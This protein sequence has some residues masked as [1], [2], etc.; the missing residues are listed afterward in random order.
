MTVPNRPPAAGLAPAGGL[1]PAHIPRPHVGAPPGPAPVAPPAGT[2][3]FAPP[4][5][6]RVLVETFTERFPWRGVRWSMTYVGFLGYIFAITTYRLPI[7]NISMVVG[8][9]GLLMQPERIR[10]PGILKGLGVFLLWCMI[11]YAVTD[12][13]QLVSDR[14]QIVGKM[15]FVALVAANA[16]RTRPQIRFAIFF[17]LACFA[18]YPVRGSIFNYYLYHETVVGRA[19]WNY[20][21]SNPNDVA[22]YCIL[23]LSLAFGLLALERKGPVRLATI[24]GLAVV[25]FLVLLTKSR[26]GFLGM[27]VFVLVALLAQRKRGKAFVI[28]GLI[29]GLVIALAPSNTL[30]RVRGLKEVQEGNLAEA[31]Q[32]GSAFQRYEIWKVAGTII[33]EHPLTGIGLGAYPAVH[34]VTAVRPQFD[35][36]AR[37]PRDTHSTYLNVTAETGLVGAA[38][39]FL[40]YLFTLWRINSVRRRAKKVLPGTARMMFAYLAGTLGFF[41]SAIFGSM[42][43]V[44]FLILEVII[45]W[46][47]AEVVERELDEIKKGRLIVAPAEPLVPQRRVA[48]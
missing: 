17:W 1:W 40:S 11:G 23:Q 21:F 47:I 38:I 28:V 22:D 3:G 43:H 4:K 18:L 27:A 20:I 5:G 16:M 15:W 30:D 7:G 10:V 45:M 29:G 39:F 42:A 13:P 36:T 26:G 37:G 41:V 2:G 19:S 14:L 34:R 35:K 12:Y 24:A 9:V 32:E 33:R 48:R 44:S 31:D 8:L 46:V 25:P 6:V